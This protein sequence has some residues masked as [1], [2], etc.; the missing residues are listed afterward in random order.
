MTRLHLAAWAMLIA[1][2]ALSTGARAAPGFPH[3]IAASSAPHDYRLV[4]YGGGGGCDD[5]CPRGGGGY[6]QP[7]GGGGNGNG[8]AIML[9]ILKG[10]GSAIQQQRQREQLQR[11]QQ[12]QQQRAIDEQNRRNRAVDEQNR[13]NR[14]IQDERNRRARQEELDRQRRQQ[15]AE[16]ERLK[17]LEQQRQEEAQRLNEQKAAD[18]QRRKQ[19]DAVRQEEQEQKKR[20]QAYNSEPYEPGEEIEDK[21][22]NNVRVVIVVV[23]HDDRPDIDKVEPLYVNKSTQLPAC[24]YVTLPADR[25]ICTG[26]TAS[27]GWLRIAS[28]PTAGGGTRSVCMSYC[29][30]AS[31]PKIPEKRPKVV[32]VTPP[33]YVPPVTPPPSQPVVPPPYQPPVVTPKPVTPA[34]ST[35]RA[36]PYV[37]PAPKRKLTPAVNTVKADPYVEPEPKRK[38][39]PAVNTAKADPYVEPEPKRKLTPAVNTVKADPYVEPEPKLTPAVLT[40][41]A[42]PRVEPGHLPIIPAVQTVRAEP[43]MEP[44][45]GQP[46]RTPAVPTVAAHP[47]TQPD[48]RHPQP[49][50]EPPAAALDAIDADKPQD[51]IQKPSRPEPRQAKLDAAQLDEPPA[52]DFTPI[53]WFPGMTVTPEST[54]NAFVAGPPK[55]GCLYRLRRQN[56]VAENGPLDSKGCTAAGARPLTDAISEPLATFKSPAFSP[57]EVVTTVISGIPAVGGVP[58][59]GIISGVTKAFWKDDSSEKLFDAMKRYVDEVVPAAIGKYDSKLL[60]EDLATIHKRMFEYDHTRTLSTKGQVL[61]S[62][63]RR[64]DD[65]QPRFLNPE[66]PK[67]TIAEFVAFG[68]L[69][70]AAL[71]ELYDHYDQ[72]YPFD[73]TDPK[74][75]SDHEDDRNGVKN[76]LNDAIKEYKDH[77]QLVRPDLVADRLNKLRVNDRGEVHTEF[78]KV[79]APDTL[80]T[81]D[82][83]SATDDSCDWHGPEY[84]DNPFAAWAD[85]ARRQA[86]VG[87]AYNKLIDELT[88]PIAQWKPM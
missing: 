15:E 64:L 1:V 27:G 34:V 10:V 19:E 21:L 79:D 71:Q 28:V 39:T 75:A 37:E 55:D 9:E 4:Q 40:L 88:A 16:R 77:I 8:G 24:G 63:V 59:G 52:P 45:S 56:R 33:A 23:P 53:P 78:F 12:Q 72:Y 65:M 62:L 85:V 5:D 3:A 22:E 69:H 73:A 48:P 66:S 82:Y 80:V 35:V 17:K 47:F 60:K 14:A 44:N 50:S 61:S 11:Q 41:R 58:V 18:D 46:Q 26:R 25:E 87:A 49:K 67:S 36:D 51:N 20:D 13:R 6:S 31:R 38:L 68:T 86:V 70:L 30:P 76:K 54:C 2:P 29:P 81:E 32:V 83:Y 57:R 43:Y 7:R 74:A 42:D 84:K